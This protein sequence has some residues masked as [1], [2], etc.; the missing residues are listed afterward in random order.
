[1]VVHMKKTPFYV[2][3]ISVGGPIY[4]LI[5]PHIANHAERIPKHGKVIVCC[6]HL[7]LKDPIMLALDAKRQIFYMA[8][9]ELFKNKFVGTI[10]RWLG[11]FSVDRGS[12]DTSAL[13][14][15]GEILQHDGA[16]G[17]FIEGTR[18]VNGKLGKPK[19]GAVMIAYQHQAPIL[20]VCITTK[21][22][23]PAKAFE[24]III[25]YG[26]VIEPHELGITEGTGSEF[27]KASR[28]VMDRIAEMRQRDEQ[29][30]LEMQRGK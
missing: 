17:I 26:E 11:A 2:F 23:K 15:C 21:T 16:V 22:G 24:K 29:T 1:M 18:S 12:G 25:S 27:R 8:K 19:S 30:F 28:I 6:N 7:S 13:D 10:L 20:P 3:S 14:R 5:Y 9:S 4:S